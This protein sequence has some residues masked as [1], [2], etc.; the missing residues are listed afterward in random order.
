MVGKV[1]VSCGLIHQEQLAFLRQAAGD[2]HQLL[3]TAANFRIGSVPQLEEPQLRQRL[4]H[5]GLVFAVGG[6]QPAEI[7]R[8]AHHHHLVDGV[9]K[10]RGVHLGDQ[11]D[12]S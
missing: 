1:E 9:A 7:G 11:A 5:N 10:G 2:Q 6:A 3:F 4:I 8:T 12:H